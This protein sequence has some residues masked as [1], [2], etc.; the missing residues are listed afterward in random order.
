MVFEAFAEV[1]EIPRFIDEFHS[2]LS[3]QWQQ[4]GRS[5]PQEKKWPPGGT[6][7]EHLSRANGRTRGPSARFNYPPAEPLA[8]HIHPLRLILSISADQASRSRQQR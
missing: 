5:M 8:E 2:T 1:I 7:I 4:S 6:D 3:I